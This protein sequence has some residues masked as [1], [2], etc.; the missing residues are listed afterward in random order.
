MSEKETVVTEIAKDKNAEAFDVLRELSRIHAV[1]TYLADPTPTLF[2]SAEAKVLQSHKRLA[3]RIRKLFWSDFPW[4]PRDDK[5]PGR[6]THK[7]SHDSTPADPDLS[8]QVR[9]NG[10]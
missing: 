1:T 5:R 8:S 4:T 9:Q 3:V 10:S 7:A 6:S 2:L